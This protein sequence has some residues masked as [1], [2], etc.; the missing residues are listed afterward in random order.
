VQRG[1]RPCSG[2]LL[3]R[4]AR[5]DARQLWTGSGPRPPA[6]TPHL[7]QRRGDGLAPA[8]TPPAGR[9]SRPHRSV[10]RPVGG[11]RCP[12]GIHRGRRRLRRARGD[13]RQAPEPLPLR[14]PAPVAPA[15][16][17]P[18]GP[19]RHARGAVRPG[20]GRGPGAA[21]A[22][23][24]EDAVPRVLGPEPRQAVPAALPLVR[25]LVVAVC[26]R[27]LHLQCRGGADPAPQGPG[28]RARTPPAR[29]G[30]RPLPSVRAPAARAAPARRLRGPPDPA[31]RGRR[32]V[33]RRG[34]RRPARPRR[35]RRR[36]WPPDSG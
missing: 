8:G 7:P 22:A 21:G 34:A 24:P 35:L 10:R 20:R 16:R 23:G 27:R 6:G 2:P 9:G 28:R 1:I 30:H 4:S 19:D 14:P 18:L 26:G 3:V 31:Q 32:P 17:R 11:R 29:R 15:R 5:G 12:R 33:A 36:P 25:A 13:D